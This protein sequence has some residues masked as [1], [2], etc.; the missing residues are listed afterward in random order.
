MT[1]AQ[2]AAKVEKLARTRAFTSSWPVVRRI[3]KHLERL[4]H[5]ETRRTDRLMLWRLISDAALSAWER[6]VQ[7]LD[8]LS[9]IQSDPALE[10]PIA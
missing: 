4:G 7:E 3:Q 2:R 5:N 9:S 6:E 10:V 8:S 1:V